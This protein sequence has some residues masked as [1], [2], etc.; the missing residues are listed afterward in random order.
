MNPIV[1]QKVNDMTWFLKARF[2][3]KLISLEDWSKSLSNVLLY[4][5]L[6]I[7]P[8]PIF[9][10]SK[11]PE[12]QCVQ[13]FTSCIYSFVFWRFFFYKIQ[14]LMQSKN[15]DFFRK[16]QIMCCTNG[17]QSQTSFAAP[18]LIRHDLGEIIDQQEIKT[19]PLRWRAL[20]FH[21][22][23]N[24]KILEFIRPIIS[25][26]MYES[27]LLFPNT[28]TRIR[29]WILEMKTSRFC[30]KRKFDMFIAQMCRFNTWSLQ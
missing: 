30:I 13:R 29:L 1:S 21:G 23:E 6:S 2:P 19:R 12:S 7:F 20:S 22:S 25:C 26:Q 4:E 14:I 8:F 18:L 16:L 28:S 5:L 3:K 17:S 11:K 9:V 15:E 10:S 27:D 24:Q